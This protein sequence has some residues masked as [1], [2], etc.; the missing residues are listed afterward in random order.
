M[1]E[2]DIIEGSGG[3]K[4]GGGAEPAQEA[5]NTLRSRATIRVLDVISEGEIVGLSTGDGQSIFIDGTPLQ[6]ADLTYN[7]ENTTY[8]IRLGQ[9]SQNPMPG[10]PNIESEVTVSTQLTNAA[11]IVRQVSA[12]LVDAVRV[13]IL[14][15][16]G[17]LS[18]DTSNG[19]INPTTVDIAIDT[20]ELAGLWT[21]VFSKTI[22][23]KTTNGNYVEAYRVERPAAAAGALWEVRARRVTADNGSSSL[24]NQT[25][26]L[27]YTEIQ[28]H[29]LTYNDT[30]YVGLITDAATT[31][32][33]IA[34]RQYLTKL[35]KVK[36][37]VNYN[38]LTRVYTGPWDGT[39][40][41][42]WTDNP[43]WHLYDMLTQIRY[44][45]GEFVNVLEIDKFSF[46]DAS[47]YNDE[48][49]ND[50]AGGVE[51]RYTFNYQFT[52]QDDTWKILQNLAGTMRA[53]V[54]P[55]GSLITLIQDRPKTPVKKISNTEIIDGL[56]TRASTGLA[57]RRTSINVTY[58]DKQNKY[59]PQTITVTDATAV[60][61]YGFNETN[62]VALG[63]TTASQALRAGR[64]ALDT[65]L[66]NTTL[67][68]FKL[69]LMHA[70]LAPG[71]VIELVDDDYS[72]FSGGGYVLAGSTDTVVNLDTYVANIAT[73]SYTLSILL[74]D[75]VTFDEKAINSFK[76]LA[77]NRNIIRPEYSRF[78]DLDGLPPLF[79]TNGTT[80][81]IDNQGTVSN[82]VLQVTAS[83][84][85][86]RTWF[87]NSVTDYNMTLTA[88]TRWLVSLD[89]Y[90]VGNAADIL[91][92]VKAADGITVTAAQQAGIPLNQWSRL[93]FVVDLSSN[94]STSGI[95]FIELGQLDDVVYFDGI[96]IEA[97]ASGS[98]P[99][100]YIEPEMLTVVTTPILAEIPTVGYSWQI[101]NGGNVELLSIIGIKDSGDNEFEI[102]A[103]N[104]DPAKYGR[105]ETGYSVLSPVFDYLSGDTIGPVS[106]LLFAEESVSN[107]GDPLAII[108]RKLRV[109]WDAPADSTLLS[110][111]KVMY[112]RNGGEFTTI[113]S[114][115][116]NEYVIRNVTFGTYE[117]IIYAV[118][119]Q[120]TVSPGI[121][122]SKVIVASGISN[123]AAPTGLQ[124]KGGGTTWASRALTIEW[125]GSANQNQGDVVGGYQINFKK[126]DDTALRT[127]TVASDILETTYL[128]EQ[129][130]EDNS[131]SPQRSVKVEVRAIDTFGRLTLP[132]TIT[133]T[134]P[135]PAAP[136]IEVVA[137]IKELWVNITSAVPTDS[138][139]TGYLVAISTT[140]GFTPQPSDVKQEGNTTFFLERNLIA[141]TTYY[142]KVAATD[143]F[144]YTLLSELSFS[145]Q[146]SGTV[147]GNVSVYSFGSS[148]LFFKAND[149][150]ANNVS[151]TAST[152]AVDNGSTTAVYAVAAGNA[153]WSSGSLYIYYVVGDTILRATT[154]IAVALAGGTSKIFAVYKGGTDV[155][156]GDGKVVIDGADVIAN[157]IGATQ[158][159]TSG[160][161]TASAQINNAIITTAHLQNLI[162]TDAKIYNL[163]G[164]KIDVGSLN[165]NRIVS[166]S[167]TATQMA[168]NSITAASGAIQDLA[169]STLKLANQ[170]VTIPIHAY[171]AGGIAMPNNNV[172]TTVQ[173]AW[174]N[175]VGNPISVQVGARVVSN[176]ASITPTSR[177]YGWWRVVRDGTIL[178]NQ[179]YIDN[180]VQSNFI[181][182]NIADTPGWGGHT[183]YLQCKRPAGA[184]TFD[185]YERSVLLLE[186]KK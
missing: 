149:P 136:S 83:A 152:I 57:E 49:I 62:M 165:A 158:V 174:I 78:V 55:L 135:V 27:S 87:G 2:F 29:Q 73:D 128:Y 122:G 48:L 108:E 42:D 124:V 50:G 101:D 30:A 154:N 160:L 64:W 74:A 148:G 95:P 164:S 179:A 134:N 111:Y 106:N 36:I 131:G 157:T 118:G 91:V 35:I 43:A 168:A 93:S 163:S 71:E 173:S 88:S 77:Q 96:Q 120:S 116:I 25:D 155:R 47:V 180:M 104:Y 22:E 127:V 132:I 45:I 176:G 33:R 81:R 170:A 161:I 107:P 121:S 100:D 80:A 60:A 175:S 167:I 21:Q 68:T 69:P 38:P 172:W 178:L 115:L 130:Y 98:T 97:M 72:Q 4:A 15:S 20:R 123:I 51:P 7:F 40:K 156:S 12:I 142:V 61:R 39:F 63:T 129:N 150:A 102:T 90:P 117:V 133:A 46:Y 153:A 79:N 18:Q 99:T 34:K 58:N 53:N 66:N 23:G 6:N 151:W 110:H 8:D 13:K 52:T 147:V 92:G 166:Y 113:D 119:I 5:P 54:V 9:A 17:L 59:L 32:N 44:G 86:A 76:H 140:S 1:K 65:E 145:A 126:T 24:K 146:G 183:Y 162:V 67:Y 112:R 144:G 31:G 82:R 125:T 138:D 186:T 37:P 141:S 26:W 94:I 103:L 11:P 114:V 41:T 85:N 16:K 3:G 19:D 143:N 171:T 56:I 109:N 70:A 159:V 139:F 14:L 182:M 84:I 137:N 181:S 89:V 184:W 10:F 177:A 28:D 169:V 185:A 105:V 75:A